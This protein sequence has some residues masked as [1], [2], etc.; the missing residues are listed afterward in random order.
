MDPNNAIELKN[1]TKTF[2]ITIKDDA[3]KKTILNKNPTKNVENT[4]LEDIS[5]NIK[6]GEVLGVIG[7]NGSGKSTLL[8]I[9]AKILE[10][11]SGTVECNGKVASILELGMGFH[12]DMSGRENIYL[13]GELYGFSKKDIDSKIDKIIEYSGV[14]KYI[15]NPVRTYSSGMN[16]RLAFSIMVNIESDIVLVDEILSVG[17]L[18][19]RDK[20][21]QHFK[22]MA[23]SGKTVIFVSHSL[24]DVESMCSRVVWIDNGRI[25]KDGIP[26]NVCSEFENIM[27]ETPEIIKDLAE[28]GVSEAQYKLAAMY[29]DGVTFEKDQSLYHEWIEKAAEQGHERAQVEFADIL[30]KNGKTEEAKRYYQSAANKG[31]N[32]AKV[33]L[34]SLYGNSDEKKSLVISTMKGL[35]EN[36]NP[37]YE[38][39]LADLLLKSAWSQ[40][41][42][43]ESFDIFLRSA[44]KGY[45]NAIHQIGLMYRDGV[46]IPRD[47]K[48]MEEYLAKASDLGFAPSVITLADIYSQGKILPKDDEKAFGLYLKAAELGNGNAMYKVATCLEEGLGVDQ[49]PKEADGWYDKFSHLGTGTH[50]IWAADELRFTDTSSVNEV[51]DFYS[52]AAEVSNTLAINNAILFNTVN[53]K[54]IDHLLAKLERMAELGNVDAMRRAAA[55]YLNGVGVKKDQK[56]AFG[57]YEKAAKLRD[58]FSIMKV[59]EMYRD[60]RGVAVDPEKAYSC[61]DEASQLGNVA[62]VENMIAMHVSGTVDKN[63]MDRLASILSNVARSGS[64][65]AARRLGNLYFDGRGVKK[66]FAKALEWYSL[67]AKLGDQWCKNRTG[68]MYRD[69]LGTQRDLEKAKEY[70]LS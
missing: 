24:T 23:S 56:T 26:K 39:R 8:S 41:D 66:D 21:K 7:R 65:D 36:G 47:V 63:D 4:V 55:I 37:V 1:V 42:K 52:N 25:R 6:K 38:F 15:D 48:K 58:G 60:G 69:G 10:P 29:R 43:K 32:D 16:G 44:E 53:G 61:F 70:F 14:K 3:G 34:S 33:K 67:A 20:A 45:P 51:G 11:S 28:E 50:N 35:A 49:N 22:N 27:S 54:P 62:A 17:D 5:L 59:G 31:D 13:K 30:M 9:I 40:E 57:W 64:A 12:P 18:S 2:K 46:G 19:F 68:E